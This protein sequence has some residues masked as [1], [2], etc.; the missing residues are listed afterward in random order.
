MPKLKNVLIALE[1]YRGPLFE[2]IAE[3]AR[4]HNWH[5]SL[6][7]LTN[8]GNIPWGWD[9]DG[10]L[11]M[12]IHDD[13]KLIRFLKACNKPTVNLEGRRMTT[14]Y[15]RVLSDTRKAAE[16]AFNYF[17]GKGFANF[18]FYGYEQSV[19]GNDFVAVVQERGFRCARFHETASSWREELAA[20]RH[21]LKGQVKPLAVF[22]WTD[23]AGARFI[24]MAHSLGCRIPAEIAVLGMDNEALICDSA[25][26]R[27]SS[28]RTDIR[29]VGYLG[30]AKLDQIMHGDAPTEET[31]LI[32][33]REVVERGSTNTLAAT[34]ALVTQAVAVMQ[35][36]Q[37]EGINVADVVRTCRVSRRG[38]EK[39]FLAGL[40]QTPHATLQ[41]IRMEHARLL[42]RESGGKIAD[43]AR[44]VGIA[45]A[46]YFSTLFLKETGL[47]P[48]D[49]R[50]SWT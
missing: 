43:I 44:Q 12:L 50:K 42:L 34:S 27:L 7:M 9:G 2:G 13:T 6:D 37:A 11:T 28:I 4:T 24:D 33:P 35:A 20:V 1:F 14:A 25:A 39:A 26:V 47:S 40:A 46:K 29:T 36:R 41:R 32:P 45:D 18:A 30:A 21:W 48:R 19:R 10:I 5:L 8:P 17:R 23:Y 3:Y 15:P 22:C 38:L 49:Y 31:R 16:M